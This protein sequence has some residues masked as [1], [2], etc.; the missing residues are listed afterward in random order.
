MNKY[1]LLMTF[2]DQIP[3]ND[4]KE[5]ILHKAD[6]NLSTGVPI[7][8]QCLTNLTRNHGVVGLISG[9]AQWVGDLALP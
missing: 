9:L 8:A 4:E 5:T 1:I 2:I 7:V 6:C 3:A